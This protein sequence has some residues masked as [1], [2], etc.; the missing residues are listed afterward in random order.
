M[1]LGDWD[2][3]CALQYD[4]TP[5]STTHSTWAGLSTS[6]SSFSDKDMTEYAYQAGV[7][8]GALSLHNFR[9]QKGISLSALTPY[10]SVQSSDVA[11]NS[12]SN[13]RGSTA[14]LAVSSQIT[15]EP[16]NL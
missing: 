3:S 4:L 1:L 5:T 12:V 16:A 9:V 11:L 13:L 14:A 7:T 10:Y 15:A 2:L 8:A 6:T